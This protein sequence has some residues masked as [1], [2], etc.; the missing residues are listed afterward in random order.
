MT[1]IYNCINS[2][3][4]C[5][6]KRW[7][8][9]LKMFEWSRADLASSFSIKLIIKKLSYQTY[10]T[11]S[12]QNLFIW[13]K[14]ENSTNWEKLETKFISMYAKFFGCLFVL[15]FLVNIFV[16]CYY[17]DFKMD[18]VKTTRGTLKAVKMIG[19]GIIG[20]LYQEC[21]PVLNNSSQSGV[22]KLYLAL[23]SFFIPFSLDI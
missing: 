16:G 6:Y 23:F 1:P 21:L 20:R 8:L 14:V 7:R 5:K 4:F 22:K 12:H 19:D 3:T 18:K 9:A 10:A 17:Q 13:T 15:A 2:S 11:V